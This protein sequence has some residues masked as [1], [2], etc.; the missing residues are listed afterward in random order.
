MKGMTTGE[1][2]PLI[3]PMRTLQLRSLF[4]TWRFSS[5]ESMRELATATKRMA[6]AAR[7]PDPSQS[8]LSSSAS[9]YGRHV[10]SHDP[11]SRS[12]VTDPRSSGPGMKRPSPRQ[13]RTG[14]ITPWEGVLPKSDMR[15]KGA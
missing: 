15:S 13:S 3:R 2:E 5:P 7:N 10:M 11:E 8:L 6:G 12:D 4:Q 14:Q 1:M 9:W